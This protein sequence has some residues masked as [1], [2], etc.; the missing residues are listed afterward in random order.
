[1]Y[2]AGGVSLSSTQ[3]IVRWWKEYFEDLLKFTNM[4]SVEEAES[5]D[6]VDDSSTLGVRSLR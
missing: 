5:L 4:S 6:G 3:D 2:S 1:M